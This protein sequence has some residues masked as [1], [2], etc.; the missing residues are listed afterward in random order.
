V[1]VGLRVGHDMLFL[2]YSDAPVTTQG[3]KDRVAGHKP[4]SVLYGRN[5]HY[6]RLQTQ[7]AGVPKRQE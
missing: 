2:K 7:P 1:I 4:V 5:F 6:K 3:V